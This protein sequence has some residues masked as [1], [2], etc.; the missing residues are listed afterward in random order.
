MEP[1]AENL[2]EPKAQII[3]VCLWNEMYSFYFLSSSKVG[4]E[5]NAVDQFFEG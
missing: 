4:I 1:S 3:I 5:N 2:H